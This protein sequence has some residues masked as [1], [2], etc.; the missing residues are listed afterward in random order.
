MNLPN[1]VASVS[2]SYARRNLPWC[3]KIVKWFYPTLA[4]FWRRMAKKCSPQYL[5]KLNLLGCAPRE[6]RQGL[7]TGVMSRTRTS[8][9][10]RSGKDTTQRDR[11]V[12][13]SLLDRVLELIA[14][15]SIC[16]SSV[17]KG[18]VCGLEVVDS[19]ALSVTQR[20]AG[21]VHWFDGFV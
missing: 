3:I 10:L 5:V 21:R 2:R 20:Q 14:R 12:R 4:I 6:F 9:L 18:D 16:A 11:A 13:L 8:G 15:R 7:R 1:S 19:T 17:S